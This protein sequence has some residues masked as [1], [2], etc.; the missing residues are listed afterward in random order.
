MK[1]TPK[2]LVAGAILATSFSAARAD[3]SINLN[4]QP[5]ATSAAPL[6]INGTT[7]LPLRDVFE[8]LGAQVNWNPATQTISALAGRTQ[9]QLGI[10]NP[11]ALVDGREIPLSQPAILS[12]GSAFVPLRFV[13]EATGAQVEWNGTLQL[14]SIRQNRINYPI[15]VGKVPYNVPPGALPAYQAPPASTEVDNGAGTQVAGL[16]QITVPANAVIP[17]RLDRAISSAQTQVGDVFTA[18]VVSNRLGDSE[19]PAATKIEAIVT[20]ARRSQNNE[21]GVLDFQFRAAILPDGTRVPLRGNLASLDAKNVS[22]QD[23]RLIANGAKKSDDL[24]VIGIGAGAGFVIG[25]LLKTNSLLATIL[26]AGGGYLV[27]KS[28]EKKAQ[29]ATLAID[30]TLGVRLLNRVRYVDR[31]EQYSSVRGD[32]LRTNNARFEADDYGYDERVTANPDADYEGY[33]VLDRLPEPADGADYTPVDEDSRDENTNFRPISI[34]AGAVVPVTL[35]AAISSAT[36]RVGQQISASVASQKLGDSEF[37]AGTK[38][39][40]RVVEAKPKNGDE[41][42]VLDLEFRT[43]LLP[44]GQRVPL[45]GQLITLDENSVQTKDGRVVAKAGG[46]NDRLKVIG[47]GAGAGYVLGRLLKKDGLLSA[48]IGALGG[49]IFD[50]SQNKNAAE[51]V[52]PAGARLGVQLDDEVSYDDDSYYAS[53]SQFLRLN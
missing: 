13:A 27:S 24:K 40:G 6:Q 23:G 29:E 14:V 11:T 44:N 43:A 12:N 9:I 1:N 10:N 41:P 3:L 20:E 39:L 38:V 42:G 26:G 4:G 30:T 5:L 45:R 8:A 37:P 22:Q 31:D 36:A 19:F 47:I 2:F 17:V 48:A 34:P 18:T 32:F 15:P 46:K 50:Q 21:P 35:D 7:L 52:V 53:R 16:R 49:F 51:A 28:R 33:E 25:K